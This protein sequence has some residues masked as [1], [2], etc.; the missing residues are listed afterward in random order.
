MISFSIEPVGTSND[1]RT[2]LFRTRNDTTTKT[3]S[4]RKSLN[5]CFFAAAARAAFAMIRL[6]LFAYSS[7]MESTA[8]NASWGISTR[9]TCFIRFFPS[10]CFS[11]SFR[12]RVI[13]P[14]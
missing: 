7:S 10:F 1:A 11:R 8:R 4:F 13:S 3:T 14:P 2:K 12:F 9:P 5:G 6:G